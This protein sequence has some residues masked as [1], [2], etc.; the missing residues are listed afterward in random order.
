M[1]FW[2]VNIKTG[3][4]KYHKK[5]DRVKMSPHTT[6]FFTST[7]YNNSCNWLMTGKALYKMVGEW[8][9]VCSEGLLCKIHAL[10]TLCEDT[11]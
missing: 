6:G 10:C 1:P 11:Q 9:K 4:K 3:V 2:V 5:V 7:A 8:K